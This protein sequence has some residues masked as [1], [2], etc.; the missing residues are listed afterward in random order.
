MLLSSFFIFLYVSG[1]ANRIKFHLHTTNKEIIDWLRKSFRPTV[2]FSR[3]TG[4]GCLSVKMG[5]WPMEA[6]RLSI[7]ADD[8]GCYSYICNYA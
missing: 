4:L 8:M 1:L 7:S 6:G 2:G 3:P 5:C